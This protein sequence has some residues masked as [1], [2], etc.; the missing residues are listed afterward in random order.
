[1]LIT[2]TPF[3]VS[4]FGGGTDL[5]SFYRKEPGKVLSTAM[6]AHM[7]ITVHRLSSLHPFRIRLS[8][9]RTEQVQDVSEIEHPV[10]RACLEML[11]IEVDRKSTSIAD[12]PARTGLGSSSS[13]TVGL[14]HALHAFRGEF[15]SASQLAE[16]ACQVEIDMLGEPI[17]KQDQYAAAFGGLREYTFMEDDIVAIRPVICRRETIESLFDN[18]LMFYVGGTRDAREI[19]QEQSTNAEANLDRLR[20]MRDMCEEGARILGG[21]PQKVTAFGK[22]LHEAWQ[23]KRGLASKVSSPE[24]DEWYARALDAGAT[25]GKL[26]GAGG[27]GFLLLFVEKDKQS[28]VREAL[29]SLVEQEVTFEPEGS[30]IIYVGRSWWK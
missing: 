13:F 10:V 28:S 11:G 20:R 21:D 23:L 7:Y 6:A 18:L 15:A 8:Y 25:G 19:L 12:I 29:G 2:C 1:M 17:G 26:L 4:F 14:L 22:L 3:R 24:I 27:T 30:R 16:E 9:S 5:P